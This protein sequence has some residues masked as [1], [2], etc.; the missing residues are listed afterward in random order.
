MKRIAAIVLLGIGVLA[1][2][3]PWIAPNPPDRMLPDRTF[4][5]PMRP[6]VFGPNGLQRPFVYPQV[7]ED[8]LVSRYRADVTETAP[9]SWPIGAPP[10]IAPQ[11]GPLLIL[12]ADSVGRDV[13][14]RLLYGARWS[15]GVVVLGALG[16]IAIGLFIGGLAAV[17]GGRAERML[18]AVTDVMLILPGVYLV[19]VL[20]AIL[21][22]VLTATQVLALMAALFAIAAWPHVARG[23]RAIL[24]TERAREYAD[25]S[26]AA[27]AGPLRLLWSLLPATR[28]F[29]AVE[30]VLLLPAL[31]VAEA[32]LS[33][34]GLGFPHP[35]PS[36]GVMLQEA[37]NVQ[38]LGGAP[39]LLAP[40]IAMFI[41]VL[42]VQ[43]ISG[44]EHMISYLYAKKGALSHV[45]SREPTV[46]ARTNG[47]V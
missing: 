29:L 16:A 24:A 22:P 17:I 34:L 31:L 46:A 36:W 35:T 37:A 7:L 43:V 30:I 9:I 20:R 23:V 6:H 15:L 14:S 38:M 27:G 11:S 10:S 40:A 13:F 5:P 33:Y 39:W 12:G 44:P 8:R 42:A 1:I 25:A 21:P 45:G 19:L 3:A 2:C 18:M 26:R 32:T 4:A 28:G 41:V 47:R